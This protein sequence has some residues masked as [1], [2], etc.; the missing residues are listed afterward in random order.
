MKVTQ[1]VRTAPSTLRMP[2]PA[3][4]STSTAAE[5]QYNAKQK[6]QQYQHEQHQKLYAH[7][8]TEEESARIIYL[9]TYVE[10]KCNF[11]MFFSVAC[12]YVT[13]ALRQ[14]RCIR[15]L[16]RMRIVGPCMRQVLHNA[17]VCPFLN[18]PK[19]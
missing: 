14:G 15:F 11:Y 9:R 1:E 12:I 3:V 16:P 13:M 10:M 4:T 7:S 18:K 5:Q 19:E 8:K 6:P 2:P 17:A